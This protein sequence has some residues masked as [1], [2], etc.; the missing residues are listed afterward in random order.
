MSGDLVRMQAEVHEVNEALGWLDK[1]VS[2]LEAMCLL[3]TEVTEAVEAY[4]E[5]G[6]ED[7]TRTMIG[8]HDRPKPE[9]VGSEFADI[10]IRLL[11]DCERF[12]V[13]LEVEYRRKLDYNRTRPYRHG[14]KLF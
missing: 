3:Y 1:P 11:D 9:G 10:L 13:D 4:R 14:N 12:G 6:L 5:H 8:M 2:F 7:Q